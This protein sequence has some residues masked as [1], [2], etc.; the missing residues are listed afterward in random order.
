METATPYATVSREVPTTMS[1]TVILWSTP[2]GAASE[3]RSTRCT[4]TVWMG[5]GA[6][7]KG[8]GWPKVGGRDVCM[9]QI[10]LCT[11]CINVGVGLV[12]VGGVTGRLK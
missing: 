3:G 2:K 4:R 1:S 5:V 6:L 9:C 8:N 7:L 11:Q 12:V 10:H